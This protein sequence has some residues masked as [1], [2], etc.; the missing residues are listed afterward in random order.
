MKNPFSRLT[1]SRQATGLGKKSKS[2]MPP[3]PSIRRSVSLDRPPPAGGRSFPGG[4][5]MG[6]T[7]R[8]G[9]KFEAPIRTSTALGGSKNSI[10]F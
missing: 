6:G 3:P 9:S 7:R 5:P 1:G 2:G 10:F 8:Q 4:L